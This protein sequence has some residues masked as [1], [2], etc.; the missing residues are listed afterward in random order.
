[1][2]E[3]SMY[4]VN[5]RQAKSMIIDCIGAGLVPYLHSSPG[6][7]KS[8]INRQVAKEFNL[9]LIDHRLSTSGPE[10]LSGLPRFNSR[11]RAEFSP[12]EDLFPLDD[13]EVPE[14][15]DGW[16]LFLDE[17]PAATKQVQAA[18]FKL[19]LD[20]MTG[21]RYLNDRVVMSCAGNLMS[22]KSIVNPLVTAMQSRLIHLEL[23]CDFDIW[24]E[25]VA[26]KEKYDHRIIGFL[27]Q[28][29]G[30]LMD[31]NP[32]H[33][34]KTF[35]CPRTW[36]FMNKLVK[37]K[38]VSMDKA[39]LYAGTVTSG[40]AV[41]FVQFCQVYQHLPTIHQICSDPT[42]CPLPGDNNL[43]WATI[44]MMADKVGEKNFAELAKY[45]DRMSI[46][47]RILFYRMCL[48]A[49]PTMR[50]HPAFVQAAVELQR[51]LGPA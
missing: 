27:N 23:V 39:A 3:V 40:V 30:K 13:D 18:S 16:M 48:M 47:F 42:N 15:H 8:S 14:G 19:I 4:T 21:Q 2:S 38:S 51:Y 11:G 17:F 28:F 50:R 26:I 37:G 9:K 6:I 36:E 22:D 12:F 33:K 46:D 44:S 1:M 7:G 32:N 45:A 41:E 10:D 35:C 43:K 20:R 29:N 25:D 49:V 24:L 5:A 31:F 34:E